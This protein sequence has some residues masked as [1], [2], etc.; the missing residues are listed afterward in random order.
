MHSQIVVNPR[1]HRG[2]KIGKGG[3]VLAAKIGPPGGPVFTGDRFFRYSPTGNLYAE[4]LHRKTSQRGSSRGSSA[5]YSSC[6]IFDLA[7]RIYSIKNASDPL[8]RNL[9]AIRHS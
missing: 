1:F 6:T 4:H 5:L 7:H 3:P 8:C 9:T 2:T